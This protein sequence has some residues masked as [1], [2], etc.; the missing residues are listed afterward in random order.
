MS[1]FDRIG[2]LAKGKWLVGTR[3]QDGGVAHEA[4]L[5]RELAETPRPR[6]AP[7]QRDLPPLEA[8]KPEPPAT[9]IELDGD[10]SVKRT[11]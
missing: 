10:G 9:P 5:D 8:A 2:N 11:L 1:I 3:P 6:P 7:L 4:G